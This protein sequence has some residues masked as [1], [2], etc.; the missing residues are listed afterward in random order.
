LVVRFK[1]ATL[2]ILCIVYTN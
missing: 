1:P 2:H